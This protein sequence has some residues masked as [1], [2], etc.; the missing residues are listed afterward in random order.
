MVLPMQVALLR[1]VT[2]EKTPSLAPAC[3]IQ[4]ARVLSFLGSSLA[5]DNLQFMASFTK[6]SAFDAVALV[7]K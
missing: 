5:A 3:Q 6:A 2:L 7:L 1:I 4:C